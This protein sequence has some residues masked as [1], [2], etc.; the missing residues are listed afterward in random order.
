V[1]EARI[2]LAGCLNFFDRP[3]HEVYAKECAAYAPTLTREEMPGLATTSRRHPLDCRVLTFMYANLEQRGQSV[4]TV[5]CP[6]PDGQPAYQNPEFESVVSSINIGVHV[7]I[8]VRDPSAIIPPPR[9]HRF[10]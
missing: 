9:V 1:L 6:F 2:D 4:P 5:R 7:Q 8:N 10:D 3:A